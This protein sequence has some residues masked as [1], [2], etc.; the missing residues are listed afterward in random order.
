VLI[1][2]IEL[3]EKIK[4]WQFQIGKL[5]GGAATAPEI[6][7]AASGLGDPDSSVNCRNNPI[8]AVD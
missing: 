7:Q 6:W 2:G 8:F 4:R 5:G 1:G 3:V